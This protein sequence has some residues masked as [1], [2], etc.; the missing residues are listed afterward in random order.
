MGL[1]CRIL[2]LRLTQAGSFAVYFN[3]IVMPNYNCVKAE[4][5]LKKEKAPKA[6]FV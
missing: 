5:S 2:K 1:V 6:P 3:E 4:H